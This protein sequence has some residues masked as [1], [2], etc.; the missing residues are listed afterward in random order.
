[1]AIKSLPAFKP[2]HPGALLRE[3][4]LPGLGMPK[5]K[6][7]EHLG[8]SRQTLYEIL[9]ERR[10]ITADIAAR[11]GRAFGNSTSFW[12]GLQAQHDA[13]HA[14]RSK[15]VKGIKRLEFERA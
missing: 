12:L 7:A 9:G 10:G 15:A 2:A 4:I 8:I 13:W 14:E 1:M 11:L 6:L 5:A 3:D